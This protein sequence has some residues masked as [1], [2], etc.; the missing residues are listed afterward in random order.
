MTYQELAELIPSDTLQRD[1]EYW[2]KTN[3]VPSG[4][5]IKEIEL[6]FTYLQEG[7]DKE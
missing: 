6:M 2:E 5:S 1:L 4:Y 7:R 3:I